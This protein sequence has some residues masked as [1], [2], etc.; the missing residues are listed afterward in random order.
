MR[1]RC[2]ED[3]GDIIIVFMGMDGSGKSTLSQSLIDTLQAKGF[4]VTYIWWLEGESTILRK[5]IRGGLKIWRKDGYNQP[6]DAKSSRKVTVWN[7]IL[8]Q[9]YPRLVLLDYLIFGIIKTR[10][11]KRREI[12]IFD[13]YYYDVI[14]ALSKEFQLSSSAQEHF[15]SI[16]K[17]F[18]PDPDLLFIFDIPP[19]VAYNRK[20]EEFQTL[21]DAYNAWNTSKH[22]CEFVED[23]ANTCIVRIDNSGEIE[24]SKREIISA[25]LKKLEKA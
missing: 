22:V 20:R 3:M 11:L 25:T 16:Y 4:Q 14:F 9:V 7:H 10:I 2:A 17:R 24:V 15:L 1:E 23:N 8:Q 13:R 12:R 6:K 21:E 18:I 19:E 5:I